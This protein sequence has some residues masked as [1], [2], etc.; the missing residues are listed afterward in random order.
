LIVKCLLDL[1]FD[2]KK[3]ASIVWKSVR[4]DDYHFVDSRIEGKRL[5]AKIEAK[6]IPSLLRTLNDYLACVSIAEKVTD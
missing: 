5:I 1:E 4:V 2:S 6:S 3:K